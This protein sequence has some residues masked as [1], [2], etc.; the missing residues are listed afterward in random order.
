MFTVLVNHHND[1]VACNRQIVKEGDF[2][3]RRNVKRKHLQILLS[4]FFKVI[5]DR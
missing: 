4:S 2:K 1:F 5:M 3:H